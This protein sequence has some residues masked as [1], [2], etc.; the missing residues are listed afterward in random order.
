VTVTGLFR[1]ALHLARARLYLRRCE[2]G[3]YVRVMGG[4]PIL[5]FAPGGRMIFGERV[6]VNCEITPV[7]LAVGPGARLVV[8][9]RTFLN[10]GCLIGA[11]ELIQ[12]GERCLVGNYVSIVDNNYHDLVQRDRMPAARAVI[13]EDDVWLGLRAIVL[14]GVHIGRGAVV[15]AGSVVSDDVPPWTVVAG[16]PARAVRRLTPPD[17]AT[18]VAPQLVPQLQTEA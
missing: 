17:H 10:Y 1:T 16:N 8:G 18:E 5:R 6:R 12:I 7:D 14:P 9:K 4:R 15:G 3:Q 13:I 2:C 11:T